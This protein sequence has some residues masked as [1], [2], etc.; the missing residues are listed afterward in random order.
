[1]SIYTLPHE[2]QNYAHHYSYNTYYGR[3]P[4][5]GYLPFST[6]ED[7]NK[8]DPN[9]KEDWILRLNNIKDITLFSTCEGHGRFLL[10]HIIFKINNLENI[11]KFQTLL[12]NIP[13][14]YTKFK[15]FNINH[16]GNIVTIVTY[17]WY[18]QD[19]DNAEW[20]VWWNSIVDYLEKHI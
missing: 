13:I 2:Y 1:M 9:L 7:E 10:T 19:Q 17:N 20:L 15:I 18:R 5:L 4:H 16:I 8:I 11:S 3:V 14:P 12:N 6:H